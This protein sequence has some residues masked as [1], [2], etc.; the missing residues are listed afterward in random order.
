MV[1]KAR[2]L[3]PLASGN[4]EL[5]DL[6]RVDHNQTLP[7]LEAFPTPYLPFLPKFFNLYLAWLE[8][9]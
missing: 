4:S 3:K 8:L 5:C 2:I 9:S 7:C 1:M 6:N